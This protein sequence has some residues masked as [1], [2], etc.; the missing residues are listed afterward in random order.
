MRPSVA[1][2]VAHSQRR[3]LVAWS[4]ALAALIGIYM[5]VWPSVKGSGSS[6]SKLIDEMPDAYKALFTN[7]AGIDFST[8]SGYLNVE[9]FT[10]MAPIA[11]LVYAIGTG[12]SAIAGEE[13]RRTIELLL[14]NRVSR[15]RLV[16]EKMAALVFGTAMLA[17]A[18]WV[19]LLVEGRIA[20]MDVPIANSAAIL[21]HLG[22]LG[23]EFGALALLVGARTGRLGLSRAIPAMTAAALYVINALGTLVGWL[24]PLRRLSPFFQYSGHDPLRTGLSPTAAFVTIASSVLLVVA[25]VRAFRRRDVGT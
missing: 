12:A 18:M 8:P 24:E 14:V 10:F 17:G 16:L 11:V 3:S 5:A 21:T 15:G 20:G 13:D 19:A 2:Q 9:L 23:I 7:G 22:L 6:F 4:I 25:A 1:V